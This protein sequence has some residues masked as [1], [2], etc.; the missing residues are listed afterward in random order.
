MTVLKFFASFM[1]DQI[2]LGR[3]KSD[4]QESLHSEVVKISRPRY[5]TE[6][7]RSVY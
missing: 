3:R 1:E 6:Q 4:L 5:I 2:F 7:I